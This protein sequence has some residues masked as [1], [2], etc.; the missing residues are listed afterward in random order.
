MSQSGHPSKCEGGDFILERTNRRMKMWMPPDVTTLKRLMRVCRNLDSI[1]KM[2]VRLV[3][4]D[5]EDLV[6]TVFR[7]VICSFI[8][9]YNISI[10]IFLFLS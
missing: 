10:I 4:D 3:N 8:F 6:D 2:K 7:F 9:V 5:A 1:D